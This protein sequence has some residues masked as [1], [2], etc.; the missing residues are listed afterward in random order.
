M[1]PDRD[2]LRLSPHVQPQVRM[3]AARLVPQNMAPGADRLAFVDGLHKHLDRLLRRVGHRD[4]ARAIAFEQVV[5]FLDQVPLARGLVDIVPRRGRMVAQP[6]PGVADRIHFDPARTAVLF[7]DGRRRRA[8]DLVNVPSGEATPAFA[9][10]VAALARGVR[11]GRLRALAE[12][13]GID[14]EAPLA[15]LAAAGALERSA[16]PRPREASRFTGSGD[17]LTWLG[18]AAALFQS[19]RTSIW[20]D[21][22]LRPVVRWR[23]AEQETLFS[24]RFADSRLCAPYGPAIAQLT[25]RDLPPPDAVLVTHQDHDHFDL[26]M[27]MMLP[28]SVPIVVPRSRPDR[29]WEVDLAAAIRAVLGGSRRVVR[30]GHGETIAV[31]GVRVTAFPFTGEMPPSLAQEWNGYLVETRRS[32]VAF[33]ADSAVGEVQVDAL[34]RRLRRRRVPLTLLADPPHAEEDVIRH[35]YREGELTVNNPERLWPWYLETWDRF[36]P[37]RVSGVASDSL[38]RL[39]REANLRH[40]FP[41]AQGSVPWCRLSDRD[42]VLDMNV[43]S[44]LVDDLVAIE[45]QLAALG[46]GVDLLPLRYGRPRALA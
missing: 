17:R 25:A 11:A 33:A 2:H 1:I 27:L 21:P 37:L 30:L 40:Y 6:R 42:N 29:P 19:D 10:I 45:R 18:H 12:R 36:T 13:A 14:V 16:P 39:A 7:M 32:A 34:V 3:G 15:A 23:P 38:A 46:A 5:A 31:G 35:G 20:V 22:C 8:R 4:P 24:A 44:L 9:R 26:G 28:P 41:Y 43:G